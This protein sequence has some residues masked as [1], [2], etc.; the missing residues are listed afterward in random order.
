M[1][2]AIR[3][4]IAEQYGRKYTELIGLVF[5]F[6]TFFAIPI[7]FLKSSGEEWRD[8]TPKGFH[9]IWYVASR[10]QYV[11]FKT[12]SYLKFALF[13]KINRLDAQIAQ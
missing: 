9:N 11:T 5:S 10:E 12:P 4:Y 2:S 3:F 6:C 8:Q 13:K 7:R 1:Y